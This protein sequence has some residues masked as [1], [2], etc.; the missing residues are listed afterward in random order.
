[1]T[2]ELSSTLLHLF[3]T[4]KHCAFCFHGVSLL[5]SK[6]R[7]VLRAER[8]GL[9]NGE[10]RTVAHTVA[11]ALSHHSSSVPCSAL[12]DIGAR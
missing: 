12:S 6:S 7:H 11:L 8:V 10:G 3:V 5:L 2:L 1:M 4:I 9:S